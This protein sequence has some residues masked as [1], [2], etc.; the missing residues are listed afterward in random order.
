MIHVFD[1]DKEKNLLAKKEAINDGLLNLGQIEIFTETNSSLGFQN[2]HLDSYSLRDKK[3]HDVDNTNI[4]YLN[5]TFDRVDRVS[6]NLQ[7]GSFQ[8]NLYYEN[9][10]MLPLGNTD[11]QEKIDT[12]GPQLFK[13]ISIS[14]IT[15]DSTTTIVTT[16]DH[17]LILGDVV[18]LSDITG[19]T[20]FNGLFGVV[21]QKIN[22][23]TVVLNIDSSTYSGTPAGGT[24]RLPIN[25]IVSIVKGSTTL[26]TLDRP[27]SLLTNDYVV[28]YGISGMT[29]INGLISKINLVPGNTQIRVEID[30]TNFSTYKRKILSQKDQDNLNYSVSYGGFV[31]KMP[32]TKYGLWANR[33]SSNYVYSDESEKVVTHNEDSSSPK[34]VSFWRAVSKPEKRLSMK[35]YEFYSNFDVSGVMSGSSSMQNSLHLKNHK[36]H[37]LDFEEFDYNLNTPKDFD[38]LKARVDSDPKLYSWLQNKKKIGYNN[39]HYNVQEVYYSNDNVYIQSTGIPD[40]LINTN[41]YFF[42]PTNKNWV[43]QIP[44]ILAT[45]EIKTPTPFGIIGVLKNG[46]PIFNYADGRSYIGRGYWNDNTVISL[47]PLYDAHNGV[48][49]LDGAYGHTMDPIGLYDES[50][51]NAHSPLLGYALDGHPIYGPYGYTDYNPTSSSPTISR[52]KSGYT[53]RN[54]TDRSIL[55]DGTTLDIENYGPPIVITD[56]TV[57]A[58]TNSNLYCF[59]INGANDDGIGATLVS[60]TPGNLEIDGITLSEDDEVLIRNQFDPAEN[61]IYVVTDPGSTNESFVLTR[62][63][64][65]KYG[66]NQKTGNKALV[67]SGLS[68]SNTYWLLT[69]GEKLGFSSIIASKFDG[70]PL[71]YFI[72]DYEYTGNGST[73][74]DQYNG[75][76]GRTPE[77]PSGIY[78][79]FV[80][81]DENKK[82]AFPYF[83]GP[84]YYGTV[85]ELTLKNVGHSKIYDTVKNYINKTLG[86]KIQILQNDRTYELT[87]LTPETWTENFSK[88]SSFGQRNENFFYNKTIALDSFATPKLLNELGF[89]TTV[90]ESL[91]FAGNIQAQ[92]SNNYENLD[93]DSLRSLSSQRIEPTFY[94]TTGTWS[95]TVTAGYR[96]FKTQSGYNLDVSRVNSTVS[97]RLDT[98]N[99]PD[100]ISIEMYSTMIIEPKFDYFDNKEYEG[101]GL[102][103]NLNWEI[104][105]ISYGFGKLPFGETPFGETPQ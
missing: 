27:H 2:N 102:F 13:K 1:I 25:S 41:Y 75:R 65:G 82:P 72:E 67:T 29:E 63:P 40:Y 60:Q 56:Y 78:A 74:L 28:F 93:I 86:L 37:F 91:E 85:S 21:I 97:H 26:V 52:V 84:S 12:D 80:T 15:K 68:N 10:K 19:A 3:N 39:I 5:D 43:F 4:F 55:P 30:S 34:N 94:S 53:L 48:V 66:Y 61:G 87:K 45:A 96:T 81:I 89:D 92:S 76:Y 54:I 100:P 42:Q 98:Y 64:L 71:G 22:S 104:Y 11:F 24:L 9:N 57:K 69:G 62:V 59:Y 47:K 18:M 6:F 58:T 101:S 49:T 35:F 83:I 46:L 77:Y 23:T 50:V 99:N 14:T 33:L 16:S 73:T 20:S 8:Q 90:E 88:S 44:R 36:Q 7:S 95:N 79:Y 51:T 103:E 38:D 31:S 70:Y 17:N 105:Q 32:T